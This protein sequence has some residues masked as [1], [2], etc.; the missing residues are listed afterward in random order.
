MKYLEHFWGGMCVRVQDRG[1]V[2]ALGEHTDS[3]RQLFSVRHQ[4]RPGGGDCQEDNGPAGARAAQGISFLFHTVLIKGDGRF[5]ADFEVFTR[6]NDE[7]ES[8]CK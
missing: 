5:R 8:P 2:G 4:H 1:K 3:C 6:V 7:K